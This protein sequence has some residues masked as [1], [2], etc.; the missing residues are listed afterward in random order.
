MCWSVTSFRGAMPS[1]LT[2]ARSGFTPDLCY[3]RMIYVADQLKKSLGGGCF[4]AK[5][6]SEKVRQMIESQGILL[7]TAIVIVE[8]KLLLWS[9][10]FSCVNKAQT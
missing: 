10:H 9:V 6:L 2:D 4:S 8:C 3:H 1:I 7:S 5:N